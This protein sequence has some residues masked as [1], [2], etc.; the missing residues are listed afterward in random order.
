M[1]RPFKYRPVIKLLLIPFFV[2]LYM[3][4]S[5]GVEPYQHMLRGKLKKGDTLL[6]R[7]E[8]FRNPSWSWNDI[9]NA[10]VTNIVTF[11]LFTDT[12]V[13]LTKAFSCELDLKIEYWSQ[14]DQ[15]EPIVK[16]H[17]PLKINFSPDSGAVYQR[18]TL[19]E[20]LNGHQ[21]KITINDIKNEGGDG[22]TPSVLQ[23]K[24]QI[25]VDRTYTLKSK[26][27]IPY[28]VPVT[29]GGSSGNNGGV[30]ARAF[31]QTPY[32]V[33]LI[34]GTITGADAYDI[35]WTF[36]DD[37][38]DNGRLLNTQANRTDDLMALMMRNNASRVTV[39]QES[40][41][42]S[43]IHDTKYLLFR[44][45]VVNYD[46]NNNRIEGP[47][48][49]KFNNQG[50]VE[51]GV[52]EL[53]TLRHQP[54]MN[55]QYAAT[56]A[57]D[58]KKKEVV[59]YFDGSGRNRQ[60]T[61]LS[62]T[63]G[64]AV[65]QETIYDEFGRPA[66]TVLPAPVNSPNLTYYVS[67]SLN[68]NKQPYNFK[69]IYNGATGF[70]VVK[71]QMM[72]P[73]G[74][75]ARYY[76][77]NNDFLNAAG[78]NKYIPAAEGYPFAVTRYTPDNTGR[79]AVQGGVGN[80]L[81]PSA[82]LTENKATRY[83][84]GKP[85]SWELDQLFGNDVGLANH[86]TKEM[87]V[88]PN[89]QVSVSYKDAAGK[90]I[91]TA[92][93]GE[94]P[95][96]T[97]KISTIRDNVTRK[98][99]LL[100]PEQFV[101][102]NATL[103]LTGT[104]TYLSSLIGTANLEY[105]I[106]QLVKNYSQNGV[107]ICSN[108]YYELR[109]SMYDDCKNQ[110]YNTAQPIQIGSLLSN[111]NAPATATGNFG[112]DLLKIGEYYVTFELSL[113]PDVIRDYTNDFIQR[114]TNLKTELQMVMD[115]LKA[116]DFTG[117][118]GDCKT[119]RQSLG[120]RANFLQ[121]LK[122]KVLTVWPEMPVNDAVFTGWADGLYTALSNNCTALRQSCVPSPCVTLEKQI[123][124][125]VSPGGQYALFDGAAPLEIP[126]NILNKYWRIKF[127]ERNPG[128]V[129]YEAESLIIDGEVTSPYDPSFTIGM[130]IKYWKPE[131]ASRFK[132]Y[133]PEY[134][135][136]RF[137]QSNTSYYAW[138]EKVKM[139]AEKV[140]DIPVV[141]PGYNYNAA[142]ADWLM[143]ADPFFN[144]NGSGYASD[145]RN[146]LLFYSDRI[147][148][149]YDSRL[150]TKSVTAFVAYSLYC[151]DDRGN[152]NSNINDKWN[153]CSPVASC[154]IP[155]R[156]W[157][158]YRDIYFDLKAKYYQYARQNEFYCGAQPQVGQPYS[159]D[160]PGNCKGGVIENTADSLKIIQSAWDENY[161][162]NGAFFLDANGQ[163]VTNAGYG[164]WGNCSEDKTVNCSVLNRVGI[165]WG[166]LSQSRNW[167]GLDA[168]FTA[169]STKTYYIGFAAKNYINIY[170][171]GKFIYSMGGHAPQENYT[172]WLML[173]IQ[174]SAGAHR[175]K[176]EAQNHEPGGAAGVEIYNLDYN[177]LTT[178][179]YDLI[180]QSRIFTT[181][182]LR[183]KNVASYVIGPSGEITRRYT[184]CNG[185]DV[186][187]CNPVG[188]IADTP[189]K[190]IYQTK[191]PRE[192]II[193]YDNINT[194]TT[195]LKLEY[196]K[197]LSQQL[198]S[199]CAKNISERKA[200]LADYFN[201]RGVSQATISLLESQL[202]AVCKRGGD[203]MHP[204]GASTTDPSAPNYSTFKAVLKNVLGISSWSMICNPWLQESPYP[205]Q[206]NPQTAQTQ[207]GFTSPEICARLNALKQDQQSQ[208]IGGT[209]YAYLTNRFGTAMN[210]MSAE[211]D[212]LLKG[213]TNCRYLLEKEIRLPVFVDGKKGCINGQ[214]YTAAVTAFNQE[215]WSDLNAGHPNYKRVFTTYLNHRW[216]FSLGYADY[217]TYAV[218]L[219]SSSTAT[220][221][222][223]PF[224]TSQDADPY[225]CL[226]SLAEGAVAQGRRVYAKYIDSVRQD[227]SRQ[228]V[229]VCATTKSAVNITT[230]QRLYHFTLYY[231]DQAGNLVRTVPP[232]GVE[233]LTD[234][235]LSLVQAAR[236]QD[237][238]TCNYTGPA[239]NTDPAVSLQQFSNTLSGTNR[240]MEM[241]L[242][243]PDP[244]AN[245]VLV[246][247]TDRKYIFN[248]C[249]DDRYLNIDIYSTIPVDAKTADITLSNNVSVDINQL[250]PL[251]Q[252]THLVLQGADIDSIPFSVY[253]NGTLCPAATNAPPGGCGWELGPDG[254]GNL[255]WPQQLSSLKQLRMY[256][257]LMTQAEITANAGEQCLGINA[258][259]LAALNPVL[260]HWARFNTPVEGSQTT[261]QGKGTTETQLSPVYPKHRLLTNYAYHSLNQVVQQ[262]TPDAGG[263]NFWYDQAG[264]L[265]ASVNAKQAANTGTYSYTRYDALGRV[266]EVGEKVGAGGLT[267]GTPFYDP[268][269]ISSFLGSGN[270]SQ[271][272][273]TYYDNAYMPAGVT[274]ISQ[275]NLRKRVAATTYQ[276]TVGGAE[277]QG[278]YYSYDALGNVKTLWQ[279]LKDLELKRIDYNYD[280]VSGKVNKVRYQSGKPDQFFYQYEYDAEN[281]LTKARSGILS[282]SSD[283]WT[284]SNPVTDAYYQYYLHGPLARTE[285]GQDLSNIQR[286]DYAYTLQGWLKGQNGHYLQPNT[287]MGTDGP[288][289][290]TSFARDA[291]SFSLD[292]FN[293]DYRPIGG[294]N[295]PA[296]PLSWQAQSGDLTGQSLYNGNISRST[297]GLNRLNNG[298]LTGYSYRYD[299]L[300]RLTRMRQ[301]NIG[302]GL[303][304]WGAAQ[305][306]EAYAEDISYDG[307]GNILKYKRNGANASGMP[308][309]MDNL[310]YQYNKSGNKL[311]NNRL[312]SISDAVNAGNYAVDL[313]SQSDNNY[314]Y[315]QIGNLVRDVQGGVNNINWN[316]Y[317]KISSIQKSDGSSLLYR[318]DAAGN[319][320]YK[321]Y[322]SGGV[323]NKEWYVRDPQ[324][325]VLAIYGNKNGDAQQ[326]WKEQH[327]YGSSHLGMWTPNMNVGS[328]NATSIWGQS[329]NRRYELSNHL[330]NVLA[331]MT[332][333][334][335]GIDANGDGTIDY[336]EPEIASAQDYYPFGMLQPGRSYGTGDYRYGFNGKEND[337][338]VK[339]QGN[340]QD[341]GMRIYDPR[342]GKFLSIDPLTKDYPY[343]SP[344]QFAGNTPTKF[345]DLDG[346]EP[347]LAPSAGPL[348]RPILGGG[349]AMPMAP[350]ARYG[351]SAAGYVNERNPLSTIEQINQAEEFRREEYLRN[352]TMVGGK[353]VPRFE[354]EARDLRNKQLG[355]LGEGNAK[356]ALFGTSSVAL[357]ISLTDFERGYISTFV[358]NLSKIPANYGVPNFNK[359]LST[360]AMRVL[361][362]ELGGVEVAQ[363]FVKQ[364]SGGYY[365]TIYG[366]KDRISIPSFSDGT[367][368]LIN[369]VHPGGTSVPSNADKLILNNLQ[370]IQRSKGMPIQSSSQ[371]IPIGNSNSKF[372]TEGQTD[373]QWKK[374]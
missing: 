147:L 202:L 161:T 162:F 200:Q 115:Q 47:W 287:E 309:D 41:R 204:N 225:A 27:V 152:T 226:V 239:N 259:Y 257:R 124:D 208:N 160:S 221:C 112:V 284:V 14:P 227:F 89:S 30:A 323:V 322:S 334:R 333:N 303:T 256:N 311:I 145:F 308:L 62:N 173:P 331:V 128:N 141:L 240:S 104:T 224:F 270:N 58:G 369:H 316:V 222:N 138:D 268:G 346:A 197:L 125:D 122:E 158:A 255:I 193:N 101:F 264:R 94:V 276:P 123:L 45:R 43:L 142:V 298:A 297:L 218:Q 286:L 366:T 67:Q 212:V 1:M 24:S 325:N 102:D 26:E 110:V 31:N 360:N 207:A 329:G 54:G 40:F 215:G 37:E 363:I 319:R 263:S 275:D 288:N 119:C 277:E 2:L 11:E 76:S 49:Y 150:V 280:L 77:S 348:M 229:N 175:I 351:V 106:Q 234:Q 292:Y 95:L 172:G 321:E 134:C 347:A 23:L 66:A 261:M 81:Q 335:R 90:V 55:W 314:I 151:A 130:L 132:E 282:S 230:A 340:Q 247:T 120:E 338:E 206:V 86:Y 93:A 3:H 71:P 135:A 267:V 357:N 148:K 237:P 113:S 361:S 65:V 251:K 295:A 144:G 39:Q 48:N 364:K 177:N 73:T 233:L 127:P 44:M 250:L 63:S 242:H 137:C 136:L 168:C 88:D 306:T 121:R 85:E 149:R 236:N 126:T 232:E 352:T 362:N 83:Y 223:Q 344:Y 97:D 75:A 159:P 60:S 163:V 343:Y 285:I 133:H 50:T 283:G 279:Q 349:T 174:L 51:Q 258:S 178:G 294:T 186:N 252:W 313:D 195:N 7:D 201:A 273:R 367:P 10:R 205:F 374:K 217:E 105:S 107:N 336:Y 211:L 187:P 190:V 153:N 170:V 157:T 9:R 19:Y 304:N 192:P 109:I 25:I 156:E 293:G 33:D 305:Q 370:E 358:E 365:S 118:F 317:G 196:G 231:Y 253:V 166:W 8:K 372:N 291:M 12:T 129:D 56:Y 315:D 21:V 70:C 16:D 278:S 38:S 245:Q 359:P 164:Y 332:D 214:E 155:D 290:P 341:Y 184:S 79:I 271:V 82:D 269:I 373:I 248:A 91:A 74:G 324:G 238:A 5:A 61:T 216:G 244:G 296:F 339:G 98:S 78:V 96:A 337:N 228:Y 35:E 326:Y 182:N 42:V 176:I 210:I 274:G 328:G 169:P 108:C 59:S 140:T 345:I 46:A 307:N 87:V 53:T 213:C 203:I 179:S 356:N 99:R 355:S 103:K 281:R 235:E 52:V 69:N 100:E 181:A 80:Q 219:A 13:A 249:I 198:D 92:L 301:H 194:D 243:S 241:W 17:I 171:D 302:T 4:V 318:Y 246:T 32:A 154:R 289:G 131:W 266:T 165:G 299:Q 183:N 260:Q 29:D 312:A 20:F 189:E 272:T 28:V 146:D 143:S 6:V 220:L 22:K 68:L 116:I 350:Y 368:Y 114:N 139:L 15:R 84:Y 342:V 327:L 353:S 300:N 167:K 18:S 320:I 57:E 34:W 188:N 354:D 265:F 310:T 330:G 371:I 72:D 64:I 191:I 199:A 254:S 209:F 36:I 185:G 117:C 180:E 262:Q 111:C